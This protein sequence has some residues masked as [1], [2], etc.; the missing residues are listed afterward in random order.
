VLDG[1]VAVIT[2]DLRTLALK[3]T[4]PV[5]FAESVDLPLA[6]GLVWAINFANL[7]RIGAMGNA[8]AG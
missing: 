6:V 3:R 7:R 4:Y 5:D 2:M 1:D 8:A